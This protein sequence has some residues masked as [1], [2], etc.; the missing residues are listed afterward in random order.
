[1]FN[2]EDIILLCTTVSLPDL[3]LLQLSVSS[4]G[5]IQLLC[6]TASDYHAPQ[7]R[8]AD[9][10]TL[11]IL[12][13]AGVGDGPAVSLGKR[14]RALKG[15][16]EEI[17]TLSAEVTTLFGILTSLHLDSS[18]LRMPTH[19]GKDQRQAWYTLGINHTT[20]DSSWEPAKIKLRWP[21]SKHEMDKLINDVERH[22]ATLT[23]ALTADGMTGI[24]KALSR[25]NA[26][27][28]DLAAIKDELKAARE[29]MTRIMIDKNRHQALDFM[30]TISTRANHEKSLR[31]RYPDTGLWLIESDEFQQ[32]LNVAKSDSNNAIA[33]FYCDYNDIAKQRT[34]NVLGSLAQQISRQDE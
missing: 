24:L 27:A 1:M 12:P 4:G 9:S 11:T 31:L 13:R 8:I 5:R 10:T 18:H 23:L 15:A 6:F 32:W 28:N 20:K 25:Q 19:I 33:Y 17:A 21:F 22:K 34:I 7:V 14:G 16:K 26:A 3:Q 29:A 2:P 30:C